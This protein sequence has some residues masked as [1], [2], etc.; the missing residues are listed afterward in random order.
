MRTPPYEY[1]SADSHLEVSPDQWRPFVDKEFHEYVPNVIKLD[2]GGDA[3]QMPGNGGVIPL[4]LNFSAGRGWE[5]IKPTGISYAEGLRG[6]GD[7]S[8]RLEEMDTDGIYAEIL[9]PAVA[10]QRGLD[11]CGLPRE[12]YVALVRGYNDWLSEEY[13]KADYQ[14]LLGAAMMPCTTVEDAIAELVRIKDMPGIRTAVLHQWPNG[15]PCPEPEDDLFWAAAVEHGVPLSIHVVFGGGAAADRRP[16]GFMGSVTINTLLT[17]GG[18]Y[19][20]FCMT[21]LITEGVF[22]RFPSLR[23]ALAETGAGWVPHYAEQ[24]DSNYKR[25]RYWADIKF[26]HEP[27][28]YVKRNFLYGIQDDFISMKIRH[29][30]GVENIMW[31]TDFPHVACDWPNDLAVADEIFR[32]VPDD[33]RRMMVRDNAVKF[34]KLDYLPVA[35]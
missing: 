28:Y 19:T 12:A 8:Q 14:R 31:A 18:A 1:V 21:Q 25:H 5:N 16:A 13:C 7:G 4:G 17:R 20:G 35:S 34:Y 29:D 26:E 9:F 2:N 11:G 32:D 30:I 24:A 33:E 3:W 10:G 15:G 6:A 23:I 22:D 27:S